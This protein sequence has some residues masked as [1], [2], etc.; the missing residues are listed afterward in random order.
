[1]GHDAVLEDKAGSP[2]MQVVPEGWQLSTVG[3]ALSIRNN[4]RKPISE[5]QRKLIPGSYPYYGPTKAQD[6][7][8]TFEQDGVF[9]LIGEDGDH[10]LKFDQMPMT[11]LVSGKCTVN[12]HA[13]IISATESCTIDWFYYYFLHRDIRSYLSRQGAGRYKLN[14][15]TL[16]RLPMLVPPRTEQMQIVAILSTW[17]RAIDA[18]EKLIGNS[19][20]QKSGLMRLLLT[21][22]TRFPEFDREWTTVRVSDVADINP[23]KPERPEDG[24]VSFI[25]MDAV[26][27]HGKLKYSETRQFDEVSQ[28]FTSFI[29]GDILVAKI[30]PCFENGKGLRAMGLCNGIGFGSTEFH[31]LRPRHECTGRLLYHISKT[32]EFRQKGFASMQGSAG[33]KRLPADFLAR[34]SFK[35]SPDTGERARV[36]ELL[37]L[38]DDEIQLLQAEV[39]LLNAEK[40]CLMQKLL[41]G[42]VRVQVNQAAGIRRSP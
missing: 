28:G 22:Q 14:K 34:Y 2:A 24:L 31:V 30:T 42:E 29:N 36:A 39:D 4:L 32:G 3:E 10:F 25:P 23:R 38:C 26:S 19:I 11:Q 12:N 18:V 1:M 37:D 40:R 13:H 7:I 6:F 33:Q 5:E 16:E 21:G 41:S 8:A 17:C 27:E 9:A 15:A 35:L 20:E